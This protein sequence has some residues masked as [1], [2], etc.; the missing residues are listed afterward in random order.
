[1]SHDPSEDY[2]RYEHQQA[3]AQEHIEQIREARAAVFRD[4]VMHL[5]MTDEIA[6]MMGDTLEYDDGD[7]YRAAFAA[8]IRSAK[9]GDA[10]SIALIK[11]M[12]EVHGREA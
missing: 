2:D 12:S 5:P 4:I 8:L 6:N 7:G 11:H 3:E 1:M 9:A 10:E